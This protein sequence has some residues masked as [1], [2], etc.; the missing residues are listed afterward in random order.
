VLSVDRRDQA[1]GRGEVKRGV[2]HVVALTVI[3]ALFEQR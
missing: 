2:E 3:F 1:H